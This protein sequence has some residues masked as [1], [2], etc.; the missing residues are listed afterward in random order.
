MDFRTKLTVPISRLAKSVGA[1]SYARFHEVLSG[2]R[3][4]SVALAKR[5]EVATDGLIRWWEFFGETSAPLVMKPAVG[6]DLAVVVALNEP[7]A[8]TREET[9]SNSNAHDSLQGVA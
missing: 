4:P 6:N 8:A 7:G 1:R 2:K 5:I 9:K 3:Q